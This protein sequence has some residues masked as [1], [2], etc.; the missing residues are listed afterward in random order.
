VSVA[1]QLQRLVDR[2][3]ATRSIR[4]ILAAI[5]SADGSLDASAAAGWT[6]AELSTGLT[7]TTPYLLASITKMYAATVIVQIAREGTIDLAA[8]IGTYLPVRLTQGLHVVDG[9]DRGPTIT[10]EQLLFQTSGLAD[11]F[12]GRPKGE[13]SLEDELRAG[14]DRELTIEDVVA[15]V[16]RLPPAFVPGAGDGRK[17]HYSDTNYAL[18][19]AIVQAVT[20]DPI[21][22]SYERRIFAPLGLEHT[23][24]FDQARSQPAPATIWHGHRPLRIPLALSSFPAD[25]GMVATLADSLRFLQGFFRGD[26]LWED[27]LAYVTGRWNRIFFP[28]RYGGGLMRFHLSRWM[29]PL[30]TTGEL[31]GHSG[32]TGSFS[33]YS[34]RR[35]VFLA[36]T[37]NQS[38]SP[39]RP[40]RLMTRMLDLAG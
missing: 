1:D 19:G 3:A 37:V 30:R 15:V 20:G 13:R 18:L 8:P 7:R 40:F 17:A 33:F 14:H 6:D 9:I 34:P 29:S 27:E 31:I 26:L 35:D 4:G 11:Y 12:S 28:M 16:R 38:D 23:F 32:S 2:Q 25:G 36:G 22:M 39:S 10:V 5:R 24:V 21:E